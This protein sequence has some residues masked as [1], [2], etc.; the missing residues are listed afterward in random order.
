ML[1]LVSDIDTN[2]LT[3]DHCFFTYIHADLGYAEQ[4]D[5]FDRLSE[6][7][8]SKIN[9]KHWQD[10]KEEKQAE[11]LAFES[12]QWPSIKVIGVKT[13]GVADEVNTLLQAAEH[14]PVVVVKPEW[15]Y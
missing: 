10:F 7:D 12:V 4:I 11:F 2:Q 5:D 6:L 15:Y 13:Q 9:K 1:H 3:N 8:F 14:K